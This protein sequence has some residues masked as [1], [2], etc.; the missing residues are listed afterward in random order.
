MSSR[1]ARAPQR[2][3]PRIVQPDRLFLAKVKKTIE[4]YHLLEK[5]DKVLVAFSGGP[6]SR[7]LLAALLELSEFYSLRLALAHFNH[8]LRPSAAE[9]E[10]FVAEVARQNALPLYLKREDIRAY[11]RRHHLNIEEAGRERR[12]AFLRQTAAR[13]GASKIATGHT[14]TDQAETFL[15]R[16]LRGTGRTGLTSVAPVVDGLVIR[17]LLGVER[18]EVES[19]LKV[20]G[21]SFRIDE[22]NFDRRYLRN[23]VRL[24]LIPFLE[25][26][27]EP[28]IVRQIARLVDVLTEEEEWLDKLS[29]TEAEKVV[30]M[31]KN[32]F[33]LDM[34]AMN[35]LPVPLA[36]RV[37]R[38]FLGRLRGDLRQVSY[39]DVESVRLLGEGKEVQVAGGLVLK[40]EKRRLFLRT[41]QPLK[42]SWEYLWDGEKDLVIP[43]LGLSFSGRR[44]KIVASEI[45]R[46]PFD[47]DWRAFLDASRLCFPLLV[48][49]RRPG[50]RYQPLGAPGQKKLKE[51]LRHRNIPVAERD[52][53]PVFF[54]AGQIAWVLGLPVAE[55]FKVTSRTKEIFIIE[56]TGS[57]RGAQR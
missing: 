39:R 43:E 23:R 40:R 34:E 19:F 11:A 52:E 28:R 18:S 2:V 45:D 38:I 51:I 50:D 9:D 4:K 44:K 31:E 8:L 37:V 13:V 10:R 30:R 41:P 29:Q 32:R 5:G 21:L 56:R 20:R 49:N 46:L 42:S 14:M 57:P 3:R 54:S 16:L 6:D 33:F 1:T 25:K 53:R 55:A 24:E 7:A 35:L 48:R 27:F 22:S 17:P 26:K 12:Y 36:R 47:D 15:L